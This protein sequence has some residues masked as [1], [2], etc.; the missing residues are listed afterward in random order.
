MGVAGVD[1]G[2]GAADEEA[3]R[4]TVTSAEAK[5]AEVENIWG[6][7]SGVKGRET[8]SV[9]IY[10]RIFNKGICRRPAAACA[11]ACVHATDDL[12]LLRLK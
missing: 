9:E 3:M 5:E 1:A 10:S 4:R 2:T 8:R 11:L 6:E 12:L 7:E